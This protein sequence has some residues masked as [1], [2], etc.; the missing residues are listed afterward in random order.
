MGLPAQ[1][2]RQVEEADRI[3]KELI[4][5][6]SVIPP[7]ETPPEV[8]PVDKPVDNS[9]ELAPELTPAPEITPP[10]D[11]GFEH[12]Y[13][14]LQGMYNSE[15]RR[16]DEMQQR[17]MSM[18]ATL[19]NMQT[20]PAPKEPV[21]DPQ[22]LQQ[23]LISADEIEDYGSDLIDV[24]KRAAQEAVQGDMDALRSENDKMKSLIGGV[25]QRIEQDDRGK[26]YD[27]LGSAVSNWE[28]INREPAF[29]QWLSEH[30]VYAGVPRGELLNRA[31]AK[32][33]ADRVIRFFKGF[34]QEN[35]AVTAAPT[36]GTPPPVQAQPRVTME[37]LVTPGAGSSG[38]ADTT[39]SQIQPW[40]ESEIAAFYAD[41]RKGL[42]KGRDD[43]YVA[44]EKSIQA[45]MSAGQILIGQ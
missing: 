3:Q 18:E 41:A 25:G 5:E 13:K 45:A 36:P 38:S 11:D 17:I 34:L 27:A 40:K 29:L 4:A 2:Q 21:V 32:N 39:S 24:M 12:K 10:V 7:T 15:K 19:Q 9:L 31:F 14:T 43:A 28:Q 6:G 35:A 44:T 22:L 20:P 37:S 42:F 8:P 23:S 33:D 26:V 16:S 1:V 30:D